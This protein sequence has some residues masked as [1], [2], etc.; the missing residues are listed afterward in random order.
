MNVNINVK[1]KFKVNGKEYNSVEEMPPDIRSVFEKAMATQGGKAIPSITQNKIIFNG[2]E[3]KKIEDMPPDIR[4]LYEQ[5]LNAVQS[6]NIQTGL[7]LSDDISSSQTVSKTFITTNMD[8]MG[9][10]NKIEP[11]A[12]SPH[13][14]IIGIVL[15]GIFIMMYLILQGK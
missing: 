4:Q 3:Y 5:A 9:I 14:L 15:I 12:F 2:V 7:N 11:T 1:R 6:G 8:K 13:L 10:P